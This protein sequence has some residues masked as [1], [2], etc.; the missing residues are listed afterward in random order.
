MIFSTIQPGQAK[1]LAVSPKKSK[2][3]QDAEIAYKRGRLAE[4]H[5]TESLRYY[6][7]AI[8]LNP[9]YVEPYLARSFYFG[10]IKEPKLQK[11]DLD[12]AVELAPRDLFPIVTRARFYANRQNWPLALR[13]YTRAIEIS[14][15]YWSAYDERAKVYRHLN[16]M[17]LAEKDEQRKLASLRQVPDKIPDTKNLSKGKAAY[18]RG[19]YFMSRKQFAQAIK[20]FSNAVMADPED[21]HAYLR[22]ADCYE[23]SGDYKSAL[24]DYNK[25]VELLPN[26]RNVY[27]SR[28]QIY[29]KIGRVDLAKKDLETAGAL[30]SGELQYQDSISFHT[31]RLKENPKDRRAYISR[32]LLLKEKQKYREAIADLTK[33]LSLN[34]ENSIRSGYTL[35]HIYYERA[36]CYENIG[37]D[38]HAIADYDSI[39]KIDN[40]AEEAFLYRGNCNAKLG[41]WDKAAQDYTSCISHNKDQTATPFL[42]RAKAYEKLGKTD[43]AKQDYQKA[44]ELQ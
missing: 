11:T 2:A 24:K 36:K 13:D 42:A 32:G 37:D 6:N 28:A 31:K 14:P 22:R 44:K 41:K 16:R 27:V 17:D 35:D 29:K 10:Q 43:L 39:L 9:K 15:Q 25:L 18:V 3:E 26:A 40:D 20:E 34:P 5:G 7:E 38:R 12:R 1:D 23:L 8:R 30:E 4:V 21:R 19:Q 33:A